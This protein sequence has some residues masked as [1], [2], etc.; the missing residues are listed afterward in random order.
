MQR[1]VLAHPAIDTPRT[2]ARSSVRLNWILRRRADEERDSDPPEDDVRRPRGD[3]RWQEVHPA[4]RKGSGVDHPVRD[5]DRD[6]DCYDNDAPA[7]RP[8]CG[9]RYRLHGEYQAIIR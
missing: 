8:L 7:L 2:V 1:L 5:R 3:D 6:G 9:V 4:E